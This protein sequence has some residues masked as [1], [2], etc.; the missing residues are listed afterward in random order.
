MNLAAATHIEVEA[1]VRYWEDSSVNGVEDG[2]GTLIPFRN[3]DAWCPII[4]LADGRVENWPSGTESSV[5]YK[6]CDAGQYWLLNAAG[7]RIAKWGGFYVPDDFLCHGGDG[8]GDYI[9]LEI[10]GDGL[11][12]NYAVPAIDPDRWRIL[13]AAPTHTDEGR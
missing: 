2:D 10:D 3:G 12:N 6:V 5:H 11:I 4:S 9:I 8:Y 13:A 1:G 7:E